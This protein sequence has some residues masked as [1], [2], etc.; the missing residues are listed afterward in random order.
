MIA[1]IFFKFSKKCAV[2]VDPIFPGGEDALE[3]YLASNIKYPKSAIKK[4]VQGTV[5]IS[6]I[7]GATGEVIHAEVVGKPNP[8]LD[9]AALDVIYNMPHWTPG[10]E[11]GKA[12][13]V[14]YNLPITFQL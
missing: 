9:P 10:L 5:R 13:N 3:K 12:V 14:S 2:D 8:E 6:F 1:I 7:I 4:G 11:K